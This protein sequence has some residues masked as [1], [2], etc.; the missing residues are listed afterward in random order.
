MEA[1]TYYDGTEDD[2]MTGTPNDEKAALLSANKPSDSY[3]LTTN[4]EPGVQSVNDLNHIKVITPADMLLVE[5]ILGKE[6]S[7]KE[8]TSLRKFFHHSFLALI[9][10]HCHDLYSSFY[11]YRSYNRSTGKEYRDFLH[12]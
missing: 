12:Q 5:S 8:G 3:E 10:S 2:D 4:T 1:E 7:Q 9:K 6:K 11:F